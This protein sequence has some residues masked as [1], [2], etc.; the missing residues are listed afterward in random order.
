VPGGL[1]IYLPTNIIAF[2]TSRPGPAL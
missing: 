2:G 1:K